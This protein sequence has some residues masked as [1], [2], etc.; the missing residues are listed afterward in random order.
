MGTAGTLFL[1]NV[2]GII[3]GI[4]RVE[5]HGLSGGQAACCWHATVRWAVRSGYADLPGVKWW[6]D[7]G[8]HGAGAW[9]DGWLHQVPSLHGNR[10]PASSIA[11]ALAGRQGEWPG[12]ETTDGELAV[13][14]VLPMALLGAGAAVQ[15]G[16]SVEQSS[17]WFAEHATRSAGY[18]HRV[19]ARFY[20][21]A[22]AQTAA[23]VIEGAPL[24]G[25]ADLEWPTNH[26]VLAYPDS[27]AVRDARDQLEDVSLQLQDLPD[28]SAFAALQMVGKRKTALRAV[29]GGM[30]LAMTHTEPNDLQPLLDR[31]SAYAE[32]GAGAVATSL[33]AAFHGQNALPV[34]AVD[35]LDVAHVADML[36]N[37]L[38][39]WLTR[40]QA[41]DYKDVSTRW[42][43][44]YPMN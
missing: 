4:V 34:A 31:V 21:A 13:A 6:A 12:A 41:N 9:P 35:R 16:H 15:R 28:P 20:A 38:V 5:L 26:A 2:E 8:L 42:L 40:D 10:G 36:A 39:D 33:A 24:D 14:R 23:H 1:A 30:A 17:D 27:R 29:S 37:D 44:R 11:S 3:R 22:L 18:T 7:N 25:F 19:E 43:S 32:P